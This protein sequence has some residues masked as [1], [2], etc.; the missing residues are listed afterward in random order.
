MK[1]GQ[2]AFDCIPPPCFRRQ[3]RRSGC[4]PALPYPPSWRAYNIIGKMIFESEEE[5]LSLQKRP[6]SGMMALDSGWNDLSHPESITT[7]R[8]YEYYVLHWFGYP[9]KNYRLLH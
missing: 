4:F 3:L 9:Q 2:Y 8:S 7:R 5:Q 1:E 6:P